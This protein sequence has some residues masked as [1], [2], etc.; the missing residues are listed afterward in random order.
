[1]VKD[2]TM[3]PSPIPTQERGKPSCIMTNWSDASGHVQ[4]NAHKVLWWLLPV[5]IIETLHSR[6]SD[7]YVKLALLI[8]MLNTWWTAL[9]PSDLGSWK[10]EVIFI[11]TSSPQLTHVCNLNLWIGL[12]LGIDPPF[13]TCH[14]PAMIYHFRLEV[15]CCMT[16]CQNLLLNTS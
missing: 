11:L 6:P 12:S 1:M 2:G 15:G 7:P 13:H 9:L 16:K 14:H 8:L 4:Q 3:S 5:R 10:M